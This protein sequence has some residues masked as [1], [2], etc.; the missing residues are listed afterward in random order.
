MSGIS[1]PSGTISG[2]SPVRDGSAAIR[3]KARSA[4]Q[5]SG[6]V[7]ECMM[8]R[9]SR[10]FSITSRIEVPG[11]KAYSPAFRSPAVPAKRTPYSKTVASLITPS[12]SS[13][14][15]IVCSPLLRGT[16]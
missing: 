13:P 8:E 15:A 9:P 7:T 16:T 1:V 10:S 14:L 11:A 6:M 12:R 3:S 5:P 2:M 4:V